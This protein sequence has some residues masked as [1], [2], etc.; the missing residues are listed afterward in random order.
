VSLQQRTGQQTSV[1]VDVGA[2]F[3]EML[4]VTAIDTHTT[5]TVAQT[6]E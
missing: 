4:L 2:E 1:V 6:I 5:P 3:R